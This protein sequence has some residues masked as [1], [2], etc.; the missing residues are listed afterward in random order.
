MSSF[1]LD[2]IKDR[3]YSSK[4][5][6]PKRRAAQTTMYIILNSL[7]RILAPLTCFTAEEIWKFM[8]KVDKDSVESVMLT[9]YPTVNKEYENEE[10]RTKWEKIVD[11]K[12]IVSKK[13]EEARAEKIIG[14]SL[15]AKVVLY[16]EGNLYEFIKDNLKLLQSVFITSGLEVEENQRNAEVKLGVKVEQAEGEKCER[17]WMYSTTVGDDK[18]NPTICHRCSEVLKG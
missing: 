15:N 10:L 16:A 2:I 1:Y 12:E 18:E 9:D 11:I 13:L 7:V 14:H 8:P 3:L 6:D 5:N 4:A 17:C